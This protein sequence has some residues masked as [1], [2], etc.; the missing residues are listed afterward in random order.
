MSIQNLMATPSSSSCNTDY[1][2]TQDLERIWKTWSHFSYTVNSYKGN[3]SLRSS[4]NI[5]ISAPFIAS[6]RF[7]EGWRKSFK[8]FALLQFACDMP[9][10]WRGVQE[11]RVDD[12][13]KHEAFNVGIT[14]ISL[15]IGGCLGLFIKNN[16]CGEML[17]LVGVVTG[18]LA[19][20]GIS[21][22]LE[23][24]RH[25]YLPNS[26]LLYDLEKQPKYYNPYLGLEEDAWEIA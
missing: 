12:A 10:V 25:H 17:S 13:L 22:E 21:R 2:P 11:G 26:Y 7:S 18:N 4:I 1:H 14:G 20:Y 5:F 16:T 24:L 19:T 8:V 3:I 6:N 15:L 9:S 23:K